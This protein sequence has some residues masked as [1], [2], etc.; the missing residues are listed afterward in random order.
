MIFD[1]GRLILSEDNVEPF[2]SW[3]NTAGIVVI[4]REFI[5]YIDGRSVLSTDEKNEAS[6]SNRA[7]LVFTRL[8]SSGI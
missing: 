4:A 7:P 1:L 6:S 8:R 5:L 3:E 2:E